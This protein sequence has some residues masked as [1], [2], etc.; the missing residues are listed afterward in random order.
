MW[1]LV[2]STLFVPNPANL[3]GLAFLHTTK[4]L[5]PLTKGLQWM[6]QQPMAAFGYLDMGM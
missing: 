5:I 6:I 1:T 3:E 4:S 2:A